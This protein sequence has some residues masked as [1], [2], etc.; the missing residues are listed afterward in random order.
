MPVCAAFADQVLELATE[1]RAHLPFPELDHRG[2]VAVSNACDRLDNKRCDCAANDRRYGRRPGAQL[3]ARLQ[4]LGHALNFAYREGCTPQRAAQ[5]RLL[6]VAHLLPIRLGMGGV[7]GL[8]GGPVVR[9]T[10]S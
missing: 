5:R 8:E 4:R 1:K 9:L 10:W 3:R 7:E 6:A 2:G